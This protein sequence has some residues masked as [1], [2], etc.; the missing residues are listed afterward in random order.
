ITELRCAAMQVGVTGAEVLHVPP[1]RSVYVVGVTAAAA[2]A[3]A[4]R[5]VAWATGIEPRPGLIGLIEDG[6]ATDCEALLAA[7]FDDAAGA[8]ISPR[9]PAGRVR[10]VHRRVHWKRGVQDRLRHGAL[11]LDLHDRVLWLDG[12][13]VSL[14]LIEFEVLRGLMRARGRA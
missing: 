13:I 14:T 10:A 5:L 9:E 1:Q 7:G 12:K 8:A 2:G 3:H 6:R 4:N 11:T